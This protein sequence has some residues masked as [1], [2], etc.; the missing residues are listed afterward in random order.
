VREIVGDQ[1]MIMAV[2]KADGYGHGALPI[3]HALNKIGVERYAVAFPDEGMMLRKGGIKNPIL[4]LGYSHPSQDAM[5]IEYGLTPTIFTMEAAKQLSE[6]AVKAGKTV[7]V[8]IKLDTGMRR[9]GFR[10][11]EESLDQIEEISRLPGIEI[12]GIFTH[13]AKADETD[14]TSAQ[15]QMDTYL[16]FVNK[17]EERGISIPVK[18]VANSASIIDLEDF[19]LDMVRAGIMTYGLYPSEEVDKEKI[20]LKPAMEWKT[21]IIYLKEIYPG[22]GVS[23]GH[24]YIADKKR[25]IATLPVGY[26]DGYPRSLSGVGRVLIRGQYAPILGRVCMD[27]MM[28]DVTEIEGVELFD[29]VTLMGADGENRISAEE[30]GS[31]SHSFNYE[32]VCDI[33]KRVPRVFY[34]N[35]NEKKVIDYLTETLT[36]VE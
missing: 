7:P 18:H 1:V 36:E 22:E 11:C 21:H 34:E 30:I 35:G 17:L 4:I 29:E 5:I 6:K 16:E 15:K 14:K 13:M 27:Q 32:I 12:E 10:P 25:K 20:L 24:T 28:V 2:I 26:A 3:A 31:L 9:I 19:R 33:S 8:H 23:Y